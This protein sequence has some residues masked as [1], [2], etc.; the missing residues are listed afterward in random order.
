MSKS[1]ADFI[2][3]TNQ[4]LTASKSKGEQEVSALSN[5][6]DEMNSEVRMAE[7]KATRAMTDAAR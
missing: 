1:L 2:I 4:A 7:E 6:L 5:D 3:C